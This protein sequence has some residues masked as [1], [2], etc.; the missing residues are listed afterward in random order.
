M[1]DFIV[2]IYEIQTPEAAI[3]M[4]DSGVDHVGTVLTDDVPERSET[5]RKTIR[6]VR[7]RSAVSSLIPLFT[8]P[9]RVNAALD[10]YRPD[11]V[12]LCDVADYRPDLVARLEPMT[13]LQEEI[14]RGFPDIRIMRSIP[15]GPVTASEGV[16]TLEMARA[17]APVSDLFLTDTLLPHPAGAQ[18]VAGF[19][20]IT[21]IPC[22]WSV[23]RQLVDES[24]IPVI[25]AG[26]LD[27]DNV[28]EGIRQVRP[29]GVD[30]CTGTNATDGSGRPIRFQKDPERVRRFVSAARRAAR[31]IFRP[32]ISL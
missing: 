28:A 31:E 17:L 27:P 21:G 30:S 26:G 12:H 9:D 3:A 18:P 23:A 22:D 6:E 1:S 11:I 19:V 5:I 15:I 13:Q 16:P 25:L 7:E 4:V 10:Y 2:Q 8:D 14:R 24:P 32:E 20:G 29:A